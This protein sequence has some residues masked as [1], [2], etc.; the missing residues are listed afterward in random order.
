VILS[1]KLE[2]R[3]QHL[4]AHSNGQLLVGMAGVLFVGAMSCMP[5][6]S[7]VLKLLVVSSLSSLTLCPPSS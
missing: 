2:R 4:D 1:S 3:Q 7:F 5:C 6:I